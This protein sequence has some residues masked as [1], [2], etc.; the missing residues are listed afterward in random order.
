[1]AVKLKVNI[2]LSSLYE[3]HKHAVYYNY[4]CAFGIQNKLTCPRMDISVTGGMFVKP[5]LN[6]SNKSKMT[7]YSRPRPLLCCMVI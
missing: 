3:L 2:T 4:A 5:K 6:S 1:M 7:P